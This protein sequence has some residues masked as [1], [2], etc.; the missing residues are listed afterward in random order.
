[1]THQVKYHWIPKAGVQSLTEADTAAIQ[2]NDLGHASKDLYEHQRVA[3]L[4]EHGP[5]DVSGPQMTHCV[6]NEREVLAA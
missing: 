1:M 3:N 5:R 6:P 2:A 4:G